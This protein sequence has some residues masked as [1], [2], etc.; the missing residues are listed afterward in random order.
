MCWPTTFLASTNPSFSVATQTRRQLTS[1]GMTIFQDKGCVYDFRKRGDNEVIVFDRS[2]SSGSCCSTSVVMCGPR[3]R[4]SKV[5]L[6]SFVRR[7]SNSRTAGSDNAMVK[8]LGDPNFQVTF[9]PVTTLLRLQSDWLTYEARLTPA[10]NDQVAQYRDFADS[11]AGLNAILYRESPPPFARIMLNKAIA[12][13]HG[14]P[15]EVQLSVKNRRGEMQSIHSKHK[16]IAKLAQ[17]DRDRVAGFRQDMATFSS[18]A[19]GEYRKTAGRKRSSLTANH[20]PFYRV[21]SRYS[22][23][24]AHERGRRSVSGRPLP[25]QSRRR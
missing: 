13:H 4:L 2:R 3:F 5:T 1:E 12:D 25:I 20:A 23:R 8:F 15:L 22:G 16:F 19:F 10:S 14:V 21:L 7:A 6:K 18:V 9:D 17:E 11:Y 24:C